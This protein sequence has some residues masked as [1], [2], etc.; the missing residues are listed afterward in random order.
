MELHSVFIS[1]GTGYLGRPL[2]AGLIARGHTVR[3]VTRP[4]SEKRLPDGA[5]YVTGDALDS[6]TFVCHVHP[7]DTFIHLTGTPKPAPW[8]GRLF[9]EVDQVSL[10]ASVKAACRAGVRHFVYVSVAHPAPVMRSYIAVRQECERIIRNSGLPATILRP[11]YVLGPG[12]WWPYALKPFYHLAEAVPQARSGA[13]RLGLVTLEQM[14]AALLA[15]VESPADGIRIF[16]VADIRSAAG[17]ALAPA[18]SL[19][20]GTLRS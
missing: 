14:T 19:D 15:A 5:G 11:W 13:R 8:K 6:S 9:R 16:E 12:H 20:P 2:G 7:A 1:G 18:A 3:S 4:G 17:H 10:E